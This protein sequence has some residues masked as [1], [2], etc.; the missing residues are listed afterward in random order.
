MAQQ[1]GSNDLNMLLKAKVVKLKVEL[2]YK[3]SK[4][5]TQ[6]NAISKFLEQKPVKLKV[7]LDA[8]AT[9]LNRQIKGIEQTI[10]KA[11]SFK[12]IKI[13]VEI[14]VKGSATA[15]K[16]QLQ[17]IN[18]VV[19][20][21]NQK[22][23]KQLKEMQEAQLKAQE[24]AKRA[25]S[26]SK[27]NIKN[28]ATVQNFNNIKNYLKQL[29]ESEKQ[30]RSK[31]GDKK[32]LFSSNQIKDANG[33]LLGFI[34][35]LERANGVVEKVKYSWNK[36][37]NQFQIIDRQTMTAVDKMVH[38]STQTLVDLQRE[39][40]KTGKASKE[41]TKEYK[42]LEK[43]GANKTLTS[44]MVKA[45]QTK[46]KN[47]QEE[48]K[49]I[50]AQNDLLREQQK[51]V[52]DIKQATK[53]TNQKFSEQAKNLL[54]STRNSKSL[55]EIKNLRVEYGKLQN[56]VKNYNKSV[57]DTQ[58]VEKFRESAIRQLNKYLRE[59]HETNGALAQDNIRAVQQLAKRMKSTKQMAEVQKQ[60]NSMYKQQQSNKDL[61][62][63]E[64]AL[65]KLQKIMTT[66]AKES[67]KSLDATNQYFENKKKNISGN[68]GLIN[69]EITKW[70]K[71]LHAEMLK[72]EQEILRIQQGNSKKLTNSGADKR[73]KQAITNKDVQGVKEYVAQ[74][75][76]ADVA[77]AKLA[78]N[79]K[80]ISTITATLAGTG[81][82]V[83]QVTYEVDRLN[84]QLKLVDNREVFNRN[85]NLGIFEQMRIA[86]ARVPVW[87][88]AMTVFYGS[89]RSVQN[90]AQE[91]LKLDKALTNLRRVA[92]DSINV[93]HIFEGATKLSKE[94]GN[95]IHDIMES[96]VDLSRT[97]GHFNE[98]QLLAISKTAI[99]MSNVSDLSA[100]DATSTLVG[101][102][103]AFNIS[104]EESIRIVDA[105]NEVDN[106]YAIS[107]QQLA[108]G[109]QKSASTARTF[110]VTLE[111]NVGHITAIGAVTM[112][113]G[114]IIGN[115][116]KTI[117]SRITTLQG[118][119]DILE[120]V[121]VELHTIGKNG[122]ED[123][124]P[125]NDILKD[126]SGR[127]F[128]L[129]D[130]QRQNIAVTVAGRYQLSRFLALMNNYEMAQKATNT[131]VFSQGSAMRENAEYL[132][133]FEARINSLK[134]GFTEFS[135]AI[136][137]AV[138][139]AGMMEL[140]RG[141]TAL[142]N[143]AVKVVDTF[144]A[145]PVLMG[146]L[147][148]V[149]LKMG[150]FK[151]AVGGITTAM[152]AMH[153]KF[154]ETSAR[155]TAFGTAMARSTAVAGAGFNMLGARA[156][157]SLVTIRT[158]MTGAMVAVRTFSVAFQS[159]LASTG[160]GLLF[161]GLGLAIEKLMRMYNEH[162][163]KQ[164]E[165][166]KLNKK[167]VD[168]Y[169]KYSDGMQ[170]VVSRYEELSKK[171]SK[172]K[173]EQ[174]E[175]LHI[176]K[177]LAE[178]LPTTVSYIDANGKAHLKS[179]K[180]IKHEVEIVK[181]LSK[182]QAELTNAK[183]IENMEKRGKAFEKIQDKIEKLYKSQRELEKNDGKSSFWATAKDDVN[184]F[185]ID[186]TKKIQE[187]KVEVLMAEAEKTEAIQKSIKAIQ[188]QTLAYFEASGKLSGLG[189]EQQAIIESF[190]SYNESML[191]HANT[192]KEFEQAY[193]DLFDIG[194]QV[195]DVFS[196]AFT[197][198]SKDMGDDPLKLQE[199]KKDLGEVSNAIPETFYQMTDEFG[200]PIKT[201]DEVTNGLKEI[202]N[203]S[204]R[205]KNGDGNWDG[206]VKR[207]QKAGLSADEAK[208]YLNG[209]AREHDNA[210]L[211]AEAQKQSVDGLVTSMEDLTEKT[212]E[213]I[214]LTSTL[215]G[216][217]STELSGVKSHLQNMHLIVDAWG[218]AGKATDAYKESQ[219]AVTDFLNISN[220]ELDKNADKIFNVIEA[221]EKVDL[222]AY[223]PS[224]SF[225][226]FIKKNEE[227]TDSQ[228]N[229][230]I[231]WAKT[232][233]AK[234]I[235][236]GANTE[237]VKSNT[238]VV[239]SV[240]E[241]KDVFEVDLNN[242]V[243][244]SRKEVENDSWLTNL[245]NKF[246]EL[247]GLGDKDNKGF[248]DWLEKFLPP[249]F[250][251]DLGVAQV[252]LEK[253]LKQLPELMSDFGESVDDA[254]GNLPSKTFKK[255]EE[256]GASIK[257]WFSGM[258]EKTST[259]MSNWG[260][261]IAEWFRTL[262]DK[263][264]P[265]LEEWYTGIKDFI[266]NKPKEI[267]LQ[268]GDW[269]EAIYD[270]FDK[271]PQETA[272]KLGE[273]T[274]S[275]I[276]FIEGM[277]VKIVTAL[278]GWK[279]AFV[280]FLEEQHEEN[281]RAY[282]GWGRSIT[283]WISS[284]PSAIAQSMEAWKEAITNWFTEKANILRDNLETWWT[285]T[286]DWWTEL[287]SRVKAKMEEMGT[288]IS[289]WFTEKRDLFYNGFD[290]W[291]RSIPSLDSWDNI[292][293]AKLEG[294]WTS[295]TNWFK[296][297]RERWGSNLETWW[298]SIKAWFDGLG[299]KKEIKDS[300]KNVIDKVKEGIE[301]KKPEFLE[302]LAEL[303]LDAPKYIFVAFAVL[304]LAVGREAIERLIQ[305]ITEGVPNLLAK[306]EDIRIA[307]I[308]KLVEMTANAYEKGK[309]ILSGVT[310]GIGDKKTEFTNKWDDIKESA[311]KKVK[312]MRDDIVSVAKTLPAKM[313]EGIK[314]MA[315]NVETGV[316]A[317]ANKIASG[318]E[319]GVNGTVVAGV[320]KVLGY[321]GV[322]EDK[323]LPK[324]KLPR[325][326]KGT[327]NGTHKGGQ[328]IV[329]EKGR[330]LA[331]LPNQGYKILG[332][333]GS[334]I[335][336]LP[337]GTSVLPN[338]E[339][340]E[341]LKSYGFP[342]Y[343]DGV[344]NWFAQ[345]FD[346]P[347]QLM[348][349]VFESLPS[350]SMP[351]GAFGDIAMAGVDKAKKGA[352]D[353]IANK[354]KDMFTFDSSMVGN[355]SGALTSWLTS[356]IKLTGVPMT[357]LPML[358][359]MAMKE[360]GGNPRAINLW[361]INAKRGIPSKGLMQTI[362]PTFNAYKM[363]G[364]NDIWNPIHN[365]VASI[366][367][368]LARYGSIF[369]TPGAKN[370]AKGGGWKGY[371]NGGI[372]DK[373]ELA[374][375]GEEGEEA[376]IPLIKKRR[377]RGIDLWVETGKR[378]GMFGGMRA[379]GGIAD[380]GGASF[381]AS[382]GEG[383]GE[384]GGGDSGSS[385]I[386]QPSKYEGLRT[387]D[388]GFD[389]FALASKNPR[390][391]IAD[392]FTYD[393]YERQS[394]SYEAQIS[395][396]EAKMSAMNKA[397]VAYR[398]NLKKVVALQNSHL[399]TLKTSLTVTE[400]RQKTIE[401]ELKKLPSLGKQSTAQRETYNRLMQEYDSNL[402]KIANLKTSIE[403][404]TNEI[405]NKSLEIFTDFIDEIV[406]KYDKSID[407]IK[408]RI[409]DTDFRIDVMTLTNPD[410]KKGLLNAQISKATDLQKQQSTAKYKV[411]DLQTE[412]DKV[413]KSK[414]K[415]SKEAQ[416]LKEQL[417]QA[418]EDYEDYTLA[419]LQAEKDIKDTRGKI[420][421]DS[422]DVLKDYH[423]NVRDMAIKAIDLEKEALEKAHKAKMDMYDEESEKINSVYDERIKA[424]DKDKQESNYQEELADKNAK[425]AELTNKISL[426][427][428][429]KSK[430]GQKK[431][432][433]AQKE[434]AELNKEITKFQQ[435]RQDEL[436]R[437]A[438]EEQKQAQLEQ[439]A[440]DKE[441]AETQHQTAL[442]ALEAQKEAVDKQ[443]EDLIN[444]D[445]Y[446]ADMREQA[447]LGNFGTISTELDKMKVN[448]DN[449]NKGI[450][451]G[452]Y[453]GFSGLSD[454]VKQ[455]IAELSG[456]TVDNMIFNSADPMSDVKEAK[457]ANP[458]KMT[459]GK[460]QS[461]GTNHST[462]NQT[463]PPKPSTSTPKPSTSK[464][465]TSKPSTSGTEYYTIKKG[466]TFS[467]I[468]KRYGLPSGSLQKLNPNVDPRKLQIGQKIVLRK[469]SSSSGSKSTGSSSADRMT[470][471]ALN[472][473]KSPAY[474][475]NVMMTIPKGAK[476]DYVGM[477]KGW[478]K[479]KY[480]GKTGYVGADYLKKFDTGGYTGDWAG[481]EGK[482][483]MLHKKELVLN[484]RQTSDIL[485]TAKIMDKVTNIMP[486]IKRSTVANKLA[487]AGSI[488][489]IT[490]GD[491]NVTVE[492]GD[493][494][495]AN[496]IAGE[497]L[498]GMKKK[499]R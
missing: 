218:E 307:I 138:L 160:I 34:A 163:R 492:N 44:D 348:G 360:S 39:L 369:N 398:D 119:R 493:K 496:D 273:W 299:Q 133:S 156:M 472:F 87:M 463:T 400:K 154:I 246:K 36:D 322:S 380:G 131:A 261:S 67:G 401:T 308:K 451:D 10:S 100:Q 275:I 76:K 191:R 376:I 62:S 169:R 236:T 204:N 27:V 450:F 494:K 95:N 56:D 342:A 452:L 462:P 495:K 387:V 377:K 108:T 240:K 381:G 210:K 296:Q 126:L 435:E 356:A 321:M 139:S 327:H 415:N 457:S 78:T 45:F 120:G 432:A 481:T 241:V 287:P 404:E 263:T 424:M 272:K 448:L 412:Y 258:P 97:F 54:S 347:K 345:F 195:G 37:K 286:I 343:E 25:T 50:K 411:D 152:T 17:D 313:G 477:E 233:G 278:I 449:M 397:T 338:K 403:N 134:N 364:L 305:G 316:K 385:G 173:D 249:S 11:K 77:T 203:V 148:M 38:K 98:R 442:D 361:D 373:M 129:S 177:E 482:I 406:T 125:V 213:A 143:G 187:N 367:Y 26:A 455:Q 68:L 157:S 478:A 416:A 329:G 344:G 488:V 208:G 84:K 383:G 499:G 121:G 301:E 115:S 269:Y 341:L 394:N 104:A 468:E 102:M 74:M 174:E 64:K 111:E 182:A 351:S 312:E 168:G 378:L 58:Q 225:D 130:A 188:A 281:K 1:K 370:M 280:T 110:G 391:G 4:L 170:G 349:K 453:A 103:N 101:T 359:T 71:K 417:D 106:D 371:A 20:G 88:G 470:T 422:I 309:D 190:I 150:V 158:A 268:M 43:A 228:K 328:A 368:V 72:S 254:L 365:A 42:E 15:I 231:E 291:I 388:G 288:A 140:I 23:G 491:I 346:K 30:L 224:D 437:T 323:K 374:W 232:D 355:V 116:L 386:L 205:V 33:N 141:L 430:E 245:V 200:K 135:T 5:P 399:A 89:I 486:D 317:L 420:A 189:D 49:A 215:F 202:I 274:G 333:Q 393:K 216:Y 181:E 165:L 81:K 466:D 251:K 46:V 222:T 167:M 176:Q 94:L 3:N 419:V 242:A 395:L 483:A 320:N 413:V 366:R 298:E 183:F 162:K 300:G 147:A 9:E 423:K 196:D 8:S 324:L 214:D 47:A 292:I 61:E 136:G 91:I 363:A 192:P 248:G 217:S 418:K 302:R 153:L 446:W 247:S 284:M 198:M 428:R 297:T 197:R 237:I 229:L 118:A 433:E 350:I 469:G 227:L 353:F 357:W 431:L 63:R 145:L 186:N 461:N 105:L 485:D 2:D 408:A 221:L 319:S 164:E 444:N 13:G 479:I 447:I 334:E 456:L 279:N 434:L 489:N 402:G 438:L 335:V 60:L 212:M 445:K 384:S 467:A 171:T 80:G 473:R 124:R 92:S 443:Y 414:G 209:L 207:L 55:E 465:S 358:Q 193:K 260:D 259:E 340:E 31:F 303:L 220:S 293:Q 339:T 21:F 282:G 79:N 206:L 392:A 264:R 99:L 159:I 41:L 318:I 48:A 379:K 389:V 315:S 239:D 325:Y 255:L 405:K 28:D 107:T 436:L 90:M 185:L 253:F 439:I 114:N 332:E 144:G 454:A 137:N 372:I 19:E 122:E 128:D 257:Q 337:K 475:N 270:W 474:G 219:E 427:S 113:S 484:E 498:K 256:W 70:N 382:S 234:D 35:S 52:R 295:V 421:D 250:V 262:P 290:N 180:D 194:R 65:M 497:I 440:Q 490:Y 178:V 459:D 172:T 226:E 425:K 235:L 460:V 53:G 223:T 310:K 75:L 306:W 123:V 289:N 464:P 285:N 66:Y 352:V 161:V 480:N 265:K 458:Y 429:D 22:Y 59:T 244:K 146:V 487:T 142:A 155:S 112:E 314:N 29:E 96:V 277:P 354:L 51:L 24:I 179:A 243:K 166:Q 7:K 69:S 211:R 294:F 82:T 18:K 330:E 109:L 311:V 12:P 407:A 362:E 199:L 409:D 426:L 396:L 410:D 283:E 276:Q 14:D 336:D 40:G 184:G 151:N 149:M 132:K 271:L 326:A 390:E 127:W 83:K 86:L 471:S 117:Y 266:A 331:Y 175:Y 230:L 85:A 476:V 32:G 252:A 304:A 375:H 73:L 93:G 267:A 441:T 201:I 6:V 238:D 57:K 16:K